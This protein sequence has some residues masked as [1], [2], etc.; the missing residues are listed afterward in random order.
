MKYDDPRFFRVTLRSDG[1]VFRYD[2]ASHGRDKAIYMAARQHG[3]LHKDVPVSEVTVEDR[4]PVPS[5]ANGY[6]VIGE[7]WLVD[8]WEW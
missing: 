2:I 6:P 1:D 4:G 8:R 5:D 3:Y 7:E